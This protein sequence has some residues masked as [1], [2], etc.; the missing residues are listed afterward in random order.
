MKNVFDIDVN[1]GAY[2]GNVFCTKEVSFDVSE[3]IDETYGEFDETIGKTQQS[4]ISII[5]ELL[6]MIIIG[7]TVNGVL[8]VGVKEAFANAPFL[9]V[10]ALAAAILLIVIFLRQ[11][12]KTNDAA[13]NG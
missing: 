2:D 3:K 4:W 13:E 11:R 7:G 9:F 6:C 10:V 1:K 8:E 12:K 5:V